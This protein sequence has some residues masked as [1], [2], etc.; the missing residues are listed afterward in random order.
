MDS[1]HP[2][3]ERAE[4]ALDVEIKDRG[5]VETVY[6]LVCA[7]CGVPA[8][9]AMVVW[10]LWYWVLTIRILLRSR[11]SEWYFVSA[12]LLGGLTA[13]YLQSVLEWVLRQQLNLI[14]LMFVFA[15]LSYLWSTVDR[16]KNL[17]SMTIKQG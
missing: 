4:E 6:L 11:N 1:D 7:E 5:I 16:K 14:C 12:G 17:A 2:Y 3:H 15:V 9:V 8:L 13:N 10:F